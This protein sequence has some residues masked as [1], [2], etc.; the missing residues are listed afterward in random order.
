MYPCYVG[1]M[2]AMRCY[3]RSVD[4]ACAFCCS[5]HAQQRAALVGG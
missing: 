3:A 1:A 4:S 2:Y 5:A